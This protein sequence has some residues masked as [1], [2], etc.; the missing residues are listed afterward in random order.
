MTLLPYYCLYLLLH[1][2]IQH[3]T[4][5]YYWR[6]TRPSWCFSTSKEQKAK[7]P[8][9]PRPDRIRPDQTSTRH[10]SHNQTGFSVTVTP[11][12]V[13]SLRLAVCTVLYLRLLLASLSS[14]F[15]RPSPS[16]FF[17]VSFCPRIKARKLPG[18]IFPRLHALLTHHSLPTYRIRSPPSPVSRLPSPPSAIAARARDCQR[19]IGK[20]PTSFVC[21]DASPDLLA[22]AHHRHVIIVAKPGRRDYHVC[23]GFPF[24]RH[25]LSCSCSCS[26]C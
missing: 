16:P 11:K 14:S 3:C 12:S 22:V 5:P 23:E 19:G 4:V 25:D 9:G 7:R 18:P 2:Y 1:P 10:P 15:A 26:C 20:I 8:G 21:V 13:D 24:S 6:S 17:R